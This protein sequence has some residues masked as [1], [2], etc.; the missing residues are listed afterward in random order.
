MKKIFEFEKQGPFWNF[1]K[2]SEIPGTYLGFLKVL[3]NYKDL[4]AKI[5]FRKGPRDFFYAVHR[6]LGH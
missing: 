3:I 1:Q 6:T 2:V 5:V 4:I